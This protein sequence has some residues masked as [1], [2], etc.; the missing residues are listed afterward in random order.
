MNKLN[1]VGVDRIT[2]SNIIKV[3]GRFPE[4]LI[5]YFQQFTDRNLKTDPFVVAKKSKIVFSL[6]NFA[7]VCGNYASGYANLDL[8]SADKDGNNLFN[9][10][11]E[12]IKNKLPD[13]MDFF[14]KRYGIQFND[15]SDFKVSKVEINVTFEMEEKPEKYVDCLSLLQY[16]FNGSDGAYATYFT[17]KTLVPKLETMY[18]V[19][20]NDNKNYSIKVYDKNKEL[21]SKKCDSQGHINCLRFE[22]TV[23]KQ[24]ELKAIIPS[25][26]LNEL[27]D[28]NI[29]NYFLKRFNK[30]IYAVDS[31]LKNRLTKSLSIA[32]GI[33]LPSVSEIFMGVMLENGIYDNKSYQNFYLRIIE[34]ENLIQLPIFISVM[35]LE[36]IIQNKMFISPDKVDICISGLESEKN[37]DLKSKSYIDA[38]YTRECRWNEIKSKLKSL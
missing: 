4:P 22:I 1:R 10:K 29:R 28:A 38:I 3:N 16:G 20:E 35:D 34:I 5:D 18:L 27:N 14:Q 13:I 8:H 21:E 12:D 31:F 36:N 11:I 33:L 7:L 30:A 37:C 6:G 24:C 32:D 25:L 23:K 9:M 19:D 17:R 15:S 2:I 26:Q